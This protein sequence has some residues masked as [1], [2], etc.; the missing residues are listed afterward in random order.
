VIT[1]SMGCPFRK[2][3][4][5]QAE[6]AICFERLEFNMGRQDCQREKGIR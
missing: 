1:M 6:S 2:K 5:P 3:R 4:R